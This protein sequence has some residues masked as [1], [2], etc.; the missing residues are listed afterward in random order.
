M[1]V[2]ETS[3][4]AEPAV[5]GWA[6][7]AED[8]V[9]AACGGMLVGIP[10]LYTTEVW[11][12]GSRTTPWRMLGV[13]LVTFGF[14]VVLNRT[15]GFRSTKDVSF[16]EA[17]MDAVDAL[18]IGIACV[19]VMLIVFQEITWQT[20]LP[21]AL[22]KV[23]YQVAPFGVGVGLASH[24]LRDDKSDADG[25]VSPPEGRLSATLADIGATVTGAVFV[26]LA[27]A[28][29][30]E[31]RILASAMN[32]RWILAML[33]VSLVVSYAI[34]FE[35]GFTNEQ[36]RHAQEGLFQSPISE[37]VVSYLLALVCAAAMLW[38]FQRIGQ[39]EPWRVTLD[40]T[41]VLGLP[42]AIGGAAGRLAV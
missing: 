22:G 23:V 9:R 7:E 34:V 40:H 10:L 28:P 8:L 3:S 38:F 36:G 21:G 33:A 27:I 17:A 35:A 12:I 37:T 16:T 14:V 4:W 41:V 32:P 39:G 18:A 2:G 1:S 11:G 30:D 24:F 13:L 20:P 19:T 29:T 26:A 42:A 25:D 15:S 6:E 31:V 5:H